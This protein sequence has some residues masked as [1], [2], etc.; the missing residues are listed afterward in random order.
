MKWFNTAIQQHH[1]IISFFL[2]LCILIPLV[3]LVDNKILTVFSYYI[4]QGLWT[5]AEIL[6][7]TSID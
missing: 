7:K 2:G 5:I 1:Q 6:W 4:T 3:I